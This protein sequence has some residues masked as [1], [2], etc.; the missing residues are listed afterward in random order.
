MNL[1]ARVI[2]FACSSSFACAFGFV[3]ATSSSACL[4]ALFAR[5]LYLY[6]P[7]APCLHK[8]P[9]YCARFCASNINTNTINCVPPSVFHENFRNVFVPSERTSC[10]INE[11][12][13]TSSS[14]FE[15][16]KNKSFRCKQVVIAL[17][18]QNSIIVDF[19]SLHCLSC[20]VNESPS[21]RLKHMIHH[22]P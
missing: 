1:T 16:K 19:A 20:V 21:F 7:G 12:H 11:E 15:A 8:P 5:V 13:T 2:C 10:V 3:I 22:H 18:C 6:Y 9:F 17:Y 4:F 14:M